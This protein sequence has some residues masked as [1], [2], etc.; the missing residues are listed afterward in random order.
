[1]KERAEALS[2]NQ[3]IALL[4]GLI[5]LLGLALRIPSM[6]DTL[7]WDELSTH[8]VVLDRSFGDM[9]DMV[10]GEQEVSPPLYFIF[11]WLFAQLGDP[12]LTMRL[13]SLI[14]GLAT[15]PLTYLL[16]A[17]TVGRKAGLF[18][19]LLIAVSP[20]MVFYSAEARPYGMVTCLTLLSTLA[21]I[22]AVRGNRTR[23]WIAFA[24]FSAASMYTHYTALFVLVA[25]FVWAFI[26][27]KGLRIRALLAA[28]GSAVLFLPW[29]PEYFADSDSPGASVI[30]ILQPFTAA[31]VRLDLSQWAL[32]H[33]FVP[34]PE[35]PGRAMQLLL[36]A[37]LAIAV[38]GLLRELWL[39]RD[40]PFFWRPNRWVVLVV[41]LAL[42]SPVIAA[43][44]SYV[45]VSVFLPRNLATSWPGLAVSMGALVMAS[46]V[47]LLRIASVSLIVFYYGFISV[48]ML[49]DAYQRP[50]YKSAAAFVA[51]RF[52]PGDR[53][54]EN[55]SPQPAPITPLDVPL[56][57]L[58]ESQPDIAEV[59]RLGIPARELSDA[60][61]QPGG[62]GRYAPLPIESAR[63]LAERTGNLSGSEKLFVI[64]PGGDPL[65]IIKIFK[66]SPLAV[67]VEALPK[68]VEPVE[69]ETFP[70]FAG[71]VSVVVFKKKP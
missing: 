70:G 40:E 2:A 60:A 55:A 51:G 62:I 19:A 59:D 65:E 57:E 50:D 34:R 10:R 12:S 32:V 31:A 45:D 63:A 68:G 35:L 64:T 18:G 16:G 13:P 33:P 29:L 26:Y 48:S 38:G 44:V 39:K 58:R 11:A 43:I 8:Y 25:Q 37:G 14:A 61:V 69:V 47:R 21:L 49:D 56:D 53:I 28:A 71:M 30:E 46:R 1:M 3:Q 67:Y 17:W 41:T 42:A 6:N 27:F 4:L 24:L 5:T 36:V 66:D 9:L 52:Q 20:F 54:V 15:I 7:L 22:A 23:W